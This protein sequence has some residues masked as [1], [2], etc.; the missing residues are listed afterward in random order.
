MSLINGDKSRE[1][2]RRKAKIKMREKG[3]EL[4][5]TLGGKLEKSPSK[6]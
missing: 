4:R 1:H 6:K 5:K 2:R 3:R